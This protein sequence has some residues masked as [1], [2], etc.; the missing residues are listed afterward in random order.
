M[1]VDATKISFTEKYLGGGMSTIIIHGLILPHDKFDPLAK[2]WAMLKRR[3]RDWRKIDVAGTFI[4][5][6]TRSIIACNFYANY[7][8]H[9]KQEIPAITE[10]FEKIIPIM[11]KTF[12]ETVIAFIDDEDTGLGQYTKLAALGANST[13]YTE[14]FNTFLKSVKLR[15][16]KDDARATKEA[17]NN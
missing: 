6:N 1:D 3:F 16:E 10:S 17:Q 7:A 14:L 4:Y 2:I 13:Y 11:M 12:E 15:T 5:D 8:G 9:E